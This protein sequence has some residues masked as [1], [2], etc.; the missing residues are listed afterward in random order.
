MHATCLLYGSAVLHDL[1]RKQGLSQPWPLSRDPRE[2]A[3]GIAPALLCVPEARARGC[4]LPPGF[5]LRY[6]TSP[7]GR[8]RRLGMV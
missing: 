2:G 4:A 8:P 3:R 5:S 1:S 6:R 7:D